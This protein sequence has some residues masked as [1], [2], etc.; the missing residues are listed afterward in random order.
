M[1]ALGPMWERYRREPWRFD[2]V[3]EMIAQVESQAQASL[4]DALQAALILSH[5]RDVRRRRIS[6]GLLAM[7]VALGD[8]TA[9]EALAYSRFEGAVN[10]E[11]LMYLWPRLSRDALRG[12]LARVPWADTHLGLV[13]ILG[14]PLR[15]AARDGWG[16][17]ALA[18]AHAVDEPTRL[19]LLLEVI[20]A[21]V[22]AERSAALAELH[23]LLRA[24]GDPMAQA[25]PVRS[26]LSTCTP[27]E[28]TALAEALAIPDTADL[29][30]FIGPA[31]A[32]MWS[33]LDAHAEPEPAILEL[34][35]SLTALAPML[36]PDDW[37]RWLRLA[38]RHLDHHDI[39]HALTVPFPPALWPEVLALLT[40]SQALVARVRLALDDEQQ[41]PAAV[42]DYL[43]ATRVPDW[44]L[45]REILSRGCEPA[46]H[47]AANAVLAQDDPFVDLEMPACLCLPA[48]DQRERVHRTIVEQPYASGGSYPQYVLD[49][50]D[51]RLLAD[52][53]A[54]LPEAERRRLV[55]RVRPH[56]RVYE[57]EAQARIIAWFGVEDPAPEATPGPA[58]VAHEAWRRQ[59]LAAAL[60]HRD[61]VARW[62]VLG[63]LFTYGEG[64]QVR[65]LY[66]EIQAGEHALPDEILGLRITALDAALWPERIARE[67]QNPDRARFAKLLL[68]WAPLASAAERPAIVER[69]MDELTAAGEP[70]DPGDL[71]A[72]APTLELSHIRRILALL[73][74]DLD[75]DHGRDL[76]D[77]AF[78]LVALGQRD[79]AIACLRRTPT[80]LAALLGMSLARGAAWADNHD[81]FAAMDEYPTGDDELRERIVRVW[82]GLG[83]C[84]VHD[85]RPDIAA[86]ISDIVARID[87]AD[88]RAEALLAGLVE[89]VAADAAIDEWVA[90]CRRYTAGANLDRCLLTLLTRL[91]ASPAATA[92]AE[93]LLAGPNG[94]AAFES[95]ATAELAREAAAHL[96]LA[97]QA[98]LLPRLLARALRPSAM[99]VRVLRQGGDEALLAAA[100][101]VLDVA[102]LLR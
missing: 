85:L 75:A 41:L 16:G 62:Q 69:A 14:A 45:L 44:W 70:V 65:A 4:L 73:P 57:P 5:L 48:A 77:L 34:T 88:L 31:L 91:Q 36:T 72:L 86:G 7:L 18:L 94:V 35:A 15:E 38:E 80:W 47:L 51:C 42:A 11:A 10:Q 67:E 66:C 27:A 53:A 50:S 83:Y 55:E 84:G 21:L 12:W 39:G 25:P 37:R 32:A 81:L 3:D 100:G 93:S 28:A 61:P 102:D 59:Q 99:L 13:R 56:L 71:P 87:D 63:E 49:M 79:E 43:A 101:R 74:E 97:T 58:P 96:S 30:G 68:W 26:L 76:C 8:L 46:R 78:R 82:D 24:L 6:G 19:A 95:S 1:Y 17:P 90:T 92:L 22:G 9:D 20:P 40:P 89:R 23:G 29:R 54:A 2:I 98:D 60:E 33:A 64:A 52:L